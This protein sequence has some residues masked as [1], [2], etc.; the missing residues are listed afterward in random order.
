VNMGDPSDDANESGI[1]RLETAPKTSDASEG[2]QRGHSS[3]SAGKPCTWRRATV[4]SVL[5]SNIAEC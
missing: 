2:S 3:Q 1:R 4:L 5:Q